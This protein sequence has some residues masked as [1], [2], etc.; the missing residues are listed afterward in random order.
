M[1]ADGVVVGSALVD[2]LKNSLDEEGKA[3]DITITAVTD[4]VKE[5]SVGVRASRSQA[6]E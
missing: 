4:L 1:D 2:A 3:T 6:A 5:L